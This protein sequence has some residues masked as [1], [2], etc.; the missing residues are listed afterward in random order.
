MTVNYLI[1]SINC[2]TSKITKWI[3]WSAVP[4]TLTTRKL[5][6]L[7]KQSKKGNTNWKLWL[8]CKILPFIF[9]VILHNTIHNDFTSYTFSI[10]R[11]IQN[12][13]NKN[14]YIC[15]EDDSTEVSQNTKTENNKSFL[16]TKCRKTIKYSCRY[17]LQESKLSKKKSKA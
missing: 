2:S 16:L 1:V 6:V 8:K 17:S 5:K 12:T 3:R 15:R 10:K 13:M 4:F 11:M 7:G 9:Y 14:K